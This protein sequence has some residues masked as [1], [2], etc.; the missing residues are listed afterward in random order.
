MKQLLLQYAAYNS[1][2]N[3][4]ITDKLKELS[5]EQLNREI[6][7]SFPSLYK[8]VLHLMDV[9]SIWWQ[10]L[11]LAEHV[12][13]PGKNFNGSFDELS[14][15]LLQ[16]SRQWEEWV[17]NANE[18]NITHVFA[19]QNSKKEQFKQPVYEMLL[20]LFNHQTFHRGQVVN[21]LRQLGIEKI[22]PTDFIV[23]SR[24]PHPLKGR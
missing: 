7:S 6:V 11:K 16:L 17:R 12:E 20:H 13:W 3:K 1:W 4:I 8:T 24:S 22:L 19:Y 21:M 5:E 10:R 14:K 23:F 9:E 2:A 15:M 18:A